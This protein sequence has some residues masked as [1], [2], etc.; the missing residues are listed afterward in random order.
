MFKY[1]WIMF[2]F[3]VFKHLCFKMNICL[4]GEQ[5]VVLYKICI[6]KLQHKTR[7]SYYVLIKKYKIAINSFIYFN[8]MN[9]LVC[10][11]K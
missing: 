7:V 1:V 11:F 6:C 2:S 10:Q 5:S 9:Y 3:C 4:F 8:S